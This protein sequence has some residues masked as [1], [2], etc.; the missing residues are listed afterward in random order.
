MCIKL[1]YTATNLPNDDNFIFPAQAYH[2]DRIKYISYT[3]KS[4]KINF[5]FQI[6][7]SMKT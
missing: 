2:L 5:C 6:F 3:K 4:Y 1:Y 7:T